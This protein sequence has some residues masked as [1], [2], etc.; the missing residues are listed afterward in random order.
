MTGSKFEITYTETYR[1]ED[2]DKMKRL[3]EWMHAWKKLLPADRLLPPPVE[4]S[5][6]EVKDS[7]ESFLLTIKDKPL[8]LA[9][10]VATKGE[11]TVKLTRTGEKS[12]TYEIVG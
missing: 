5:M 4:M 10:D 11:I 8:I 12:F 3:W 1:G 2:A 7:I 9:L 6:G